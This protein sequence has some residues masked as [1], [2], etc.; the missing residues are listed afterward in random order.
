MVERG[1]K[2][3]KKKAKTQ[4]DNHCSSIEGTTRKQKQKA[5]H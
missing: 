5:C 4:E 1:R 2:K 3:E